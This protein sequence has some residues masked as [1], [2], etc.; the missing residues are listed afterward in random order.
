M[1]SPP[2]S[3]HAALP[4]CRGPHPLAVAF[5]GRT[6]D[7]G[8]VRR[9]YGLEGEGRS[10]AVFAYPSGLRDESGRFTWAE[11]GDPPERLRDYA[12]FDRLLADLSRQIGRD[13]VRTPATNAPLVCRPLLD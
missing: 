4:V 10:G 2:R 6:S 7:G 12:L 5:H 11:P 8:R 9:Y 13:P 1:Y 3:L